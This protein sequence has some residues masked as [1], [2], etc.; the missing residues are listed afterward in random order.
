MTRHPRLIVGLVAVV[1]AVALI[2]WGCR[3][4]VPQPPVTACAPIT[5][6][7]K[8][9]GTLYLVVFENQKYETIIEN[10][11]L[12]YFR[13]LAEENSLATNFYANTHPSLGNYFM[14]TTG[15]II[16]NDLNFNLLIYQ[17]NIATEMCVNGISWKGYF[18]NMP[19]VGYTKDRAF[20]YVKAH[21][22]FAYFADVARNPDQAKNMVP[23]EE[24]EVDLK[25][26]NMPSFAYI[27][28]NQINN[29]HDCPQGGNQCPNDEKLPVAD[30][31]LQRYIAPILE[32]TSFKKNGLMIITFDESFDTDPRHGGGHIVTML[33]GP[34]VK[35]NYKSETFYQLP[36]VLRLICDKLKIPAMGA[37]VDAPR[38]TEFFING[39]P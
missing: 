26:D 15:E 34:N 3:G 39:E 33:I 22:P 37:G 10:K 32:S 18:E 5:S 25:N 6:D 9:D 38:M 21:N 7:P 24:L 36:S 28:P 14:M 19:Q 13:Q 30:A 17:D 29:M 1:I 27:I 23:L 8:E 2:A 4:I 11:Y 31:W 35:K 12:P 16:T 20:P